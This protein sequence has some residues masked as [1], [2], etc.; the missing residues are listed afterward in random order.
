MSDSRWPFAILGTVTS[1]VGSVVS[2]V[3]GVI[4]TLSGGG[5]QEPV[6]ETEMAEKIGGHEDWE[7]VSKVRLGL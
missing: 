6:E 2:A 5:A 7:T 4:E 3:G 1:G